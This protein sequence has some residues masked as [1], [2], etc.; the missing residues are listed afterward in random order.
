MEHKNSQLPTGAK[1]LSRKECTISPWVQLVRKEVVL[2]SHQPG[3]TYHCLAQADCILIVATTPSGLIPIVRQFR[4]AAE[5]YTWEL[6]AG[7]VDEGEDPAQACIRELREETGLETESVVHFGTYIVDPVRLEYRQH[8][9]HV[10]TAEPDSDFIPEPG[11]LVWYVNLETL[12]G[13]IRDNEF[14]VQPH[15]AAV[16]QYA[17]YTIDERQGL[18]RT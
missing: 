14:P 3:K 11:M 15:I 10:N 6:P 17:L 7:L 12:K 9:F 4:P 18:P 1:T 8:V 2:A 5:T 13:L 16:L